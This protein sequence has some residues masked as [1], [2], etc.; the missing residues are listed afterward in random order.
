MRFKRLIFS[1]FFI[2]GAIV[3]KAESFQVSS[4]DKMILLS[5][6]NHDGLS[7]SVNFKDKEIIQESRLGFEFKN[8]SPMDRGFSVLEKKETTINETW[9][10]VIK[11]KHAVVLNN[12]NELQLSLREKEGL[13][14]KMDLFFRVFNDGVAFRYKLYRSEN[15]GQRQITKE[16]TT[17][18]IPGNPKAWVVEYGKYATS[19]ES[20]FFEHPLSYVRDTTIAGLPFL[21]DYGNNCWVA[22]TEAHIDNYAAFYIGTNGKEN[23][24]DDKAFSFAGRSRIRCESQI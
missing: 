24:P 2:S 17:F 1:L 21:M 12:C 6:I 13:M 16:L 3:L 9:K 20:E 15:V 18:N 11:S 19:N 14:R 10:P 5:I 22:I 8:E 23:S 7:Y 4:P